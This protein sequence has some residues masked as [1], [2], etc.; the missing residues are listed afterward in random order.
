VK[1]TPE[2]LIRVQRPATQ[3]EPGALDVPSQANGDIALISFRPVRP[4]RRA[5]S[6]NRAKS[7]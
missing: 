4:S 1:I 6:A 7:D 5:R 2:M 3:I